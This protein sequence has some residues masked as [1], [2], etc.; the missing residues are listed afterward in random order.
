MITVFYKGLGLAIPWGIVENF[1]TVW[2]HPELGYVAGLWAGLVCIYALPPRNV[3]A[4]K[5]ALIGI[6]MT[7]VHPL[8]NLAFTHH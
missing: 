2:H 5:Y 3:E 4:W 6:T 1:L 7:I 8:I